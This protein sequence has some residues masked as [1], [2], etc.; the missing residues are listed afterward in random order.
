[1]LILCRQAAMGRR[2]ISVM[3]IALGGASVTI[4]PAPAPALKEASG[5]IV[6]SCLLL[7]G[8]IENQ[9]LAV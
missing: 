9:S 8:A 5:P 1:M 7:I 6:E 3:L 2:A 4:P